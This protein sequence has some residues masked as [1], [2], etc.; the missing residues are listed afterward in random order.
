MKTCAHC[1]L[2]HTHNGVALTFSDPHSPYCDVCRIRHPALNRAKCDTCSAFR[3]LDKFPGRDPSKPCVYC[4][5][6]GRPVQR[7]VC[8]ACGSLRKLSRFPQQ[9]ATRPCLVC[10]PAGAR[11]SD[12]VTAA[13][14]ALECSNL[15]AGGPLRTI[16]QVLEYVGVS[17]ASGVAV[18]AAGSWLRGRGFPE[19]G[20]A[21]RRGYRVSRGAPSS[22][23]FKLWADRF[24]CA[25][26]LGLPADELQRYMKGT[27]PPQPVRLAM[28]A[29]TAGLPAWGAA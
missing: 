17:N 18:R 14:E 2:S 11:N 19:C 6:I 16:T 21:G 27:L 3:R 28:S 20:A 4:A 24:G 26:A 29:L 10:E 22:P 12:D 7:A 5:A 8:G 15:E 23:M 13:V 25:D 1:N 9:D